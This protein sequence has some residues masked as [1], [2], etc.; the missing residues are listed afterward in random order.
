MIT[1][2]CCAVAAV[3]A[4]WAGTAVAQPAFNIQ[5]TL[6]CL[7]AVGEEGDRAQCVGAAANDCMA[8]DS[9]TMMMNYCFE[10]E[11]NWWDGELNTAY[12]YVKQQSAD[13]DAQLD[14]P[15]NVQTQTLVDMQR[16]WITFR[17]ARCFWEAALWQGGT[18]AGPAQLSCL[19]IETARQVMALQN[20]GLAY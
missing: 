5:P 13:I 14:P 3:C 12:Q 19:M 2:I 7:E 8:D 6:D 18:G 10:M 15:L 20:S 17:D 9:S 16:A 11:Y 1:K 4:L